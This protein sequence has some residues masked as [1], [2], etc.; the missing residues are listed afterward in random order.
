VGVRWLVLLLAVGCGPKQ[1]VELTKIPPRTAIVGEEL[2]IPLFADGTAVQFDFESDITDLKTRRLHA[3][4]TPYADGVAIFRWIPLGRD[5]GEHQVRFLVETD[6]IQSSQVVKV[7]VLAGQDAI[8]FREPVGDGTT[9]DLARAA[10]AEVG[11]LVEDA[12]A[13]QVTLAPGAVWADNAE[14]TQTGALEGTLRF[15]PSDEQAQAASIFP[16]SLSAENEFGGRAEKRYTIVLGSLTLPPSPSPG[17][18]DLDPPSM[19]HQP[20]KDVTT[21]NSLSF[22]V[23]AD[24]PDGVRAATVFW[25][26]ITADRSQMSPLP[27]L[28]VG[29]TSFAATLTNPVKDEPSGTSATVYYFIRAADGADLRPGCAANLSETPNHSFV[30]T[31]P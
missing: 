5:V 23:D 16:L 12:G 15:C 24:D 18:C 13:L 17:P 9:L 10:C 30:V 28:Y 25:S 21:A 4:L 29:G 26:T 1:G 8:T 14:L 7:T 6:G 2:Q 27:M 3:I 22:Y 20:Q 19:A 31:A 11:I